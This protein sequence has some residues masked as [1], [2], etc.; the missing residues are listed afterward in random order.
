MPKQCVQGQGLTSEEGADKAVGVGQPPGLDQG[1]VGDDHAPHQ[2]AGEAFQEGQCLGGAFELGLG[3]KGDAQGQFEPRGQVGVHLE[4]GRVQV[5]KVVAVQ[6]V[7]QATGQA[8]EPLELGGQLGLELG[9]RDLLGAGPDVVLLQE[10]AV[11]VHQAG[12]LLR[13]AGLDAR[14]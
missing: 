2:V 13:L 4:E 6:V 11:V 3:W 9:Q 14:R 7:R 10:Q 12:D 8:Y 5:D 1:A